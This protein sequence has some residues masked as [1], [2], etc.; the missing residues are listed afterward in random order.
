MPSGLRAV[1]LQPGLSH[2]VR[3]EI[4]GQAVNVLSEIQAGYDQRAQ[5][6]AQ[7]SVSPQE[8]PV[9]RKATRTYTGEA[10]ERRKAWGRE[11]AVFGKQLAAQLRASEQEQ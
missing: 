5:Q 3:R 8:P 2:D 9:R 10:L 6:A 1:V 7:A 11:R 4:D